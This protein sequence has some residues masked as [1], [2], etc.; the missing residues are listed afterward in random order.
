[1]SDLRKESQTS[2]AARSDS[3]PRDSIQASP[4]SGKNA[5]KKAKSSASTGKRSSPSARQRQEDEAP[6]MR[7]EILYDRFAE[8]SREI[9]K[10]YLKRDMDQTAEDMRWLG[11]EAEERLHPSRLGAGALSSMAR[12][13]HATGS[14]LS[15]VSRKAEEVLS[16]Q[17]GELT[18]AGT[19]TCTACW[20]K[21]QRKA[22]GRIPPCPRCHGTRFRKGY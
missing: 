13:L 18:S 5:G 17:T 20:Q 12:L 9:F 15:S 22:T 6:K 1:M 10:T 11:Q 16:Y 2:R 7:P 19:L 3:P 8:K 14:A 4:A 21:V